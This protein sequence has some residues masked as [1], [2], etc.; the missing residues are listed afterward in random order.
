MIEN[1]WSTVCLA[2]FFNVRWL[3]INRI[4][5]IYLLKALNQQK[6]NFRCLLSNGTNRNKGPNSLLPN[7]AYRCYNIYELMIQYFI[8]KIKIIFVLPD[9]FIKLKKIR[10]WLLKNSHHVL[11]TCLT[12]F[13]VISLMSE[14]FPAPL[15]CPSV[16]QSVLVDPPAQFSTNQFHI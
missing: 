3:F 2:I 15:E 6:S 11:L 10:F 7:Y 8:W 4:Q 12:R 9:N 13:P 16:A 14:L 1:Q 5:N